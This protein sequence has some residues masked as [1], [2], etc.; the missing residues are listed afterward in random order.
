MSNHSCTKCSKPAGFWVSRSEGA[1]SRR[2]WCLLCI[3]KYLRKAE[4][5]IKRIR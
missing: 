2:P 1:I 3:D 5:V 4:F